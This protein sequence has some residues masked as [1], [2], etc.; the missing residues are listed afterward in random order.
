V[1][2]NT[3]SRTSD[4]VT[5]SVTNG[6][7][8]LSA[9]AYNTISF[10]PNNFFPSYDIYRSAGGASQGYVGSVSLP[11]ELYKSQPYAPLTF[12]DNG[13]VAGA[14]NPSYDTTANLGIFG[15]AGEGVTIGK[16]TE[17]LA[18]STSGATTDT[19][20]NMLPAGAILLG[21]VARIE[22]AITT[23][24]TWALG[25][26]S[27][28]AR[29]LAADNVLTVGHTAIGLAHWAGTV[30]MVQ[31]AAA[32]LR[33]TCNGTPGAGQLRVTVFYLLFT[34]PAS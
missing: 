27:T 31:A 22:Q 12:V 33:I 16:N 2:G 26:S 3:G 20:G 29:F 7:T 9:A 17:L 15:G 1:V 4:N 18:L 14:A 34:P 13:I 28:A 21:I 30:A 6:P 19:A 24:T 25:D 10:V 11:N 23:A 5:A 32:K 8:T